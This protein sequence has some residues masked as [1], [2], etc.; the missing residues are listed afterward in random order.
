[1]YPFVPPSLICPQHKCKSEASLI[2][3]MI[4]ALESGVKNSTAFLSLQKGSAVER[5]TIY[6]L[7]SIPSSA[8]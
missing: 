5:S 3:K 8:I 6:N 2:R 7:S 1:M 4:P